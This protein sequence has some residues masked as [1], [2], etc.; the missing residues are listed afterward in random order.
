MSTGE[1]WTRERQP[2]IRYRRDLQRLQPL[3]WAEPH[4]AAGRAAQASLGRRCLR[5]HKRRHV[6]LPRCSHPT[7]RQAAEGL[8]R[9][10]AG[11]GWAVLWDP[12]TEL[13][14]PRSWRSVPA[15]PTRWVNGFRYV[16]R[17]RRAPARFRR[18]VGGAPDTPV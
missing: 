9:R 13:R 15:A 7:S 17:G 4:L 16:E 11:P 3:D 1:E 5:V 8:G 6:S 2:Q 14:V 10:D 18:A 12:K